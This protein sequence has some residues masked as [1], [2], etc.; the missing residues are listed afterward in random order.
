MAVRGDPTARS[1]SR[2]APKTA[3]NGLWARFTPLWG[4]LSP[5]PRR[6][7]AA[8]EALAGLP[9]R[10]WRSLS[11]SV[12]PKGET[13]ADADR[14]GRPFKSRATGV[15]LGGPSRPVTG[16]ADPTAHRESSTLP[17]DGP[18]PYSEPATTGRPQPGFRPDPRARRPAA[19]RAAG[20]RGRRAAGP[21]GPD[22]GL[23]GPWFR[24]ALRRP[25]DPGGRASVG[26][27]ERGHQ[28]EIRS[29]MLRVTVLARRS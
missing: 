16:R 5:I 21:R 7:P 15:R 1:F 3:V 14:G 4:L 22:P 19:G 28:T 2:S 25:S 11:P 10:F 26:W 17:N 20:R 9:G 6:S 27:V 13:N 23:G 8:L 29:T 12:A 24:P 18:G